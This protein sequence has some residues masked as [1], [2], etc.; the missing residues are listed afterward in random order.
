VLLALLLGAGAL[1]ATRPAQA[2]IEEKVDSLRWLAYQYQKAGMGELFNWQDSLRVCLHEDG[3]GVTT[4]TSGDGDSDGG[5]VTFPGWDIGDLPPGDGISVTWEGREPDGEPFDIGI[6]RIE[7]DGDDFGFGY[8]F[9]PLDPDSIRIRIFDGDFPVFDTTIVDPDPDPDPNPDP[10][11][12]PTI[13]FP[14][15]TQCDQW[16]LDLLDDDTGTSGSGVGFDQNTE[17]TFSGGAFPNAPTQTIIGN[18][19]LI[20]PLN[21][22]RNPRYLRSMTFGGDFGIHEFTITDAT[23]RKFGF[24]HR[25][26]AEGA[27]NVSENALSFVVDP[28]TTGAE[29]IETLFRPGTKGV[30]IDLASLSLANGNAVWFD[31][32]TTLG[33]KLFSLKAQ[34]QGSRTQLTPDALASTGW[35]KYTVQYVRNGQVVRTTSVN[36]GAALNLPLVTLKGFGRA[37]VL[38]EGWYGFYADVVFSSGSTF[39]IRFLPTTNNVAFD[40][41]STELRASATAGLTLTILDVN[42]SGVAA[43]ANAPAPAVRFDQAEGKEALLLGNHPN[44]FNPA[45]TIAYALPVTAHVRLAVYDVMG[46]LVA[47]LADGVQQAGQYEARFDATHLASGL[48]FYRL[49]AGRLTQTRQML[50]VK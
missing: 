10:T 50:L 9:D 18:R 17:F 31:V 38:E 25:G 23:L 5:S 11:P 42:A 3:D 36:E 45:T 40:V 27:Y 47:T 37:S 6:I 48:Y 46:R 28:G 35:T 22:K 30:D 34:R 2:Q 24:D 20:T 7:R 26:S 41:K 8:D 4:G 16:F 32:S 15:P 12:P 14:G 1:F 39:Q 43:P 21:T 19:I 44:P 33:D 29:G 13:N 49:E